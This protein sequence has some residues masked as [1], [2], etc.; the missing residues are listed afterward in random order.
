MFYV[1]ATLGEKLV[2]ALNILYK[3]KKTEIHYKFCYTRKNSFFD[4][5]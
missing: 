2:G 4:K 1:N 3:H 5:K